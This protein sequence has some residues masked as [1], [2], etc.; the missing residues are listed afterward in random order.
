MTRIQS[1]NSVDLTVLC[2]LH[3]T[4]S[5]SHCPQDKVTAPGPGIEGLSH[6]GSWRPLSLHCLLLP[7]IVPTK[8][9][10]L[11]V[12]LAA[13]HPQLLPVFLNYSTSEP[14]L[15][16]VFC[17]SLDLG[18]RLFPPP[19]PFAYSFMLDTIECACV[20]GF[21]VTSGAMPSTGPSTVAGQCL[22][23]VVLRLEVSQDPLHRVS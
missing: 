10:I 16:Y 22:M 8:P 12:S 2:S 5:G 23:S 20:Q 6:S 11:S 9:F 4:F 15:K 17:D 18:P 21:G 19:S 14:Q 3:Q 7:P 1:V 13:S